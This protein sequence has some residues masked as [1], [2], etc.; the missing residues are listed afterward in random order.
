MTTIRMPSFFLARKTWCRSWSR[1]VGSGGEKLPPR[2]VN[3]IDYRI[4]RYRPRIEGLFARIERWTN[5]ADATDTF[6]RSISK[7]N[8]LTLYGKNAGSRVA[9][10]AAPGISSPG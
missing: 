6:W 3:G 8:I 10:P 7:D 9:D 1:S 5:T 2:R 4:Q